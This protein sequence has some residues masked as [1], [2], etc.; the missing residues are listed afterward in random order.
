MG[1]RIEEQHFTGERALFKCHNKTIS[2]CLFDDGESPLK[3]G[4]NLIVDHCTFGWKYPLWYGE[5]HIVRNSTFLEMAR[6]GLWYTNHSTFE[7]CLLIAP[8]LF[9]RSH[10]LF[11][12]DIEFKDAKETLWTCGKVTL[13][14]VKAENGD[15]F[16]KDSSDVS[17]DNLTLNGN[18]CFDGGK[19][20]CVRNSVLNSKD[21]FWNCENV[22]VENSTIVGEYFG[23][24]SKDIVLKNCKVISH[25]GFCYIENLKMIDCIIE[26]SDLIFE[27]CSNIDID[28]KS[29]LLSVKNP[30]S[31]RISSYGID[32]LILD[33]ESID[34]SKVEYS[35][36]E[37]L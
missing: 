35:T 2:H 13:K 10:D 7:N 11:L 23:W 5:N 34:K 28:V 12:S 25:Q 21:A 17:V 3:E 37:T 6:S 30:L 18:Y 14:N 33:D 24:N 31:G 8:K 27:Y 26:D 16:L 9:R 29:R 32:E 4:R 22:Y 36:K 20:I 15:Y 19:N 1:I